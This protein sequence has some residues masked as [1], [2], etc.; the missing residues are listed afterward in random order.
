LKGIQAAYNNLPIENSSSSSSP[1]SQAS[2]VGAQHQYTRDYILTS[3]DHARLG[4]LLKKLERQNLT[5]DLFLRMA[6]K[7]VPLLCENDASK[8]VVVAHRRALLIALFKM[9]TDIDV[10][11]NG[12]VDFEELCNF[13]V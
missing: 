7:V 5:V 10:D 6:V 11:C 2:S 12:E 4:L 3:I 1:S 8:T 13:L 9:F